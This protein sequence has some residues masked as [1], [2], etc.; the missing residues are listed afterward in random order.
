MSAPAASA[1]G[2]DTHLARS[3]TSRLSLSRERSREDSEIAAMLSQLQSAAMQHGER[4]FSN[5][6]EGNL[7]RDG[8]VSSD[9]LGDP[10]VL[11]YHDAEDASAIQS[12]TRLDL[13]F[14]SQS[15]NEDSHR[16][17]GPP[18]GGQVC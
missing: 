8:H 17:G 5:K 14:V 1:P 18:F 16:S 3:D 15:S 2:R 6:T 12:N 13:G 4:D 10:E 7:M 11:E 9:R